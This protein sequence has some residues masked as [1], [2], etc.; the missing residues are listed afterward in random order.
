MHNT[1][2]RLAGPAEN[3]IG[4]SGLHNYGLNSVELSSGILP[5][6]TDPIGRVFVRGPIRRTSGLLPV[7][8]DTICYGRLS[9]GKAAKNPVGNLKDVLEWVRE[10]IQL[11]FDAGEVVENLRRERYT[12]HFRQ[13]GQLFND[14]L[15]KA[16]YLTRPLLGAVTRDATSRRSTARAGTKISFPAWPVD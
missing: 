6:P 7:G 10:R 15:R 12:A 1:E 2:T 13:E 3:Y 11:P 4:C 16:Y 14:I 9:A 5:L 8:P